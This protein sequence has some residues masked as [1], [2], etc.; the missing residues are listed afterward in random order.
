MLFSVLVQM[1]QLAQ[2]PTESQKTTFPALSPQL[3]SDYRVQMAIHLC[4]QQLR[5]FTQDV[6]RSL[7]H[8]AVSN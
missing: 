7:R 8:I 5:S 2:I 3:N 4:L 1:Q 6:F